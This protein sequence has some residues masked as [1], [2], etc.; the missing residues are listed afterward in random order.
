[1]LILWLTKPTPQG[2]ILDI[3]PTTTGGV[4]ETVVTTP[5]PKQGLAVGTID[6]NTIVVND[7]KNDTSTKTSSNIPQHYFLS[8]GTDPS[9]TNASHSTF[10]LESDQSFNVTLLQEPIGQ[11]RS[12]AETELIQKLGISQADMCRL[13]YWVGVP[14]FINSIYSGKNLGFSFCPGAAQL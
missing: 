12:Q 1:M 6:G 3:T 4:P 9:A 13:R 8:G 5:P 2:T 14:N 10:Y 7:F 11:V